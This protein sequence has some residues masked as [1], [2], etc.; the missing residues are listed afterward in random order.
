VSNHCFE[1]CAKVV[2]RLLLSKILIIMLLSASL[3][4]PLS[5]P[6]STSTFFPDAG[7]VIRLEYGEFLTHPVSST[8]VGVVLASR[9]VLYYCTFY[10]IFCW[11]ATERSSIFLPQ[12]V[13]VVVVPVILLL[14]ICETTGSSGSCWHARDEWNKTPHGHV[15]PAKIIRVGWTG[16]CIVIQYMPIVV[17]R[18][19]KVFGGAMEVAYRIVLY[20]VRRDSV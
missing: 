8:V 14:Y 9:L 20:S 16:T 17:Q 13:V 19:R 5:L 12:F 18:T 6:W 3:S 7:L 1:F 2:L 10:A 11:K 15:C 4:P